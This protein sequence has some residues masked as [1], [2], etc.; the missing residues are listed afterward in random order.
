MVGDWGEGDGGEE[1]W[2]VEGVGGAGREDH[3]GLETAG[4][5]RGRGR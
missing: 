5:G 4:T 3:R 1:E 2:G